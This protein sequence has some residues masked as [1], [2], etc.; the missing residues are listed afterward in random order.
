[1]LRH[2][3]LVASFILVGSVAHADT[4][5]G[6]QY[7][8]PPGYTAQVHAD[9]LEL[10]KITGSTFCSIALFEARALEGT[11]RAERAFEWKNVV[12]HQFNANVKR[13][14]TMQTK[15]GV[16]VAA[17]VAVLRTGEGTYGAVHYVVMPPGMIGS[18]LLTSDTSSTL[19]ACEPVASAL[20][21]SLAID[22][23]A[24]Q[25]NDPEARVQTPEG[26][27]SVA[28][29]NSREY[30]FA[31]DGTY[32]FYSEVASAPRVRVMVERGT[33]TL[34]GNQLTLKPIAAS[35]YAVDG[36]VVK[37]A[38]RIPLESTT[39]TWGK[40]YVV[41]TNEWQLVLESKKATKRDG[42]R[43]KSTKDYRYSDRAK[44]QW[45]FAP[46]AGV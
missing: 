32:R 46:V 14:T 11:V 40:R 20:V 26:R 34:L 10:T 30:T 28:G 29:A 5:G 21:G 2:S 19:K 33:Y 43:A 9:H 7:T 3:L 42:A 12:T 17:T 36:G 4:F 37:H 15:R 27:W 38:S 25:F 31:S 22:W 24:P 45:K 41:E 13:R 44:P 39:Y 8:A 23:N 6:W 16:Q 1:M 35:S 18:V